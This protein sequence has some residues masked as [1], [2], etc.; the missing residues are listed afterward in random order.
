MVTQEEKDNFS[1]AVTN[2][3]NTLLDDFLENDKNTT[4]SFETFI[5]AIKFDLKNSYEHNKWVHLE[6]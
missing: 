4:E 5:D 3:F 1:I 2:D 6:D